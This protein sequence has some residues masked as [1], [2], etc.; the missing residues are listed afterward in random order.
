MQ[1]KTCSVCKALKEVSCFSRNLTKKDGLNEDC[2]DCHK[3]YRRQYYLDNIDKEKATS[4]RNTKKWLLDTECSVCGKHLLRRKRDLSKERFCSTHCMSI[5]MDK[6]PINYILK[7][8]GKRAQIKKIDFNLTYEFVYDLFYNKQN[9]RC[10]VTNVP[11]FIKNSKTNYGI[12]CQASL[13]R[14]DNNKGYIIGNVRLVVL[15]INYLKS[16][17]SDEQVFNLL[18]LICENYKRQEISSVCGDGAAPDL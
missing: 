6:G 9:K 8:A 11:I 2:K 5:F 7:E 18:N 14:I 4:E 3:I 1:T 13:D 15:G 12:D 10:A 16:N 17:R